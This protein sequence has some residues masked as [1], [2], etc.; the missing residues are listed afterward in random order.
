VNRSLP[1]PTFCHFRPR[2]VLAAILVTALAGCGGGGGDSTT[3]SEPPGPKAEIGT[4]PDAAAEIMEQP[5]YETSR[6]IYYVGDPES[7]DALLANRP[8]EMVLTGSTAKEFV[9]GSVYDTLGTDRRLTTP[10]YA[11]TPVSDGQVEGDLVLVASGD[12]ALGGRNAPNDKFDHTFVGDTVDH[13]YGNIAPNADRVGDPLAGLN[14]LAEQ[15]AD[16]G[17]ERVDGDVVIDT[18]LWDTFDG[19]EGPLT[20]IFVN[21]NIVDLDVTGTSE[22]EPAEVEVTPETGYFEVE[23][24][25]ETVGKDG[26][27]ELEVSESPD[28]PAVLVV[29]GKIAEGHSQLAIFSVEDAAAW[30]RALFIEALERADVEVDAPARGENDESGL[31]ASDSYPKDQELASLKSPPLSAFGSTI[32]EVSYNA[33]ANAFLCLLAVEAGSKDCNTGLE[34]MYDLAEEA[35]L[36]T[37]DLFLVDGQGADPASTTPRQMGRWLQWSMEQPWGEV[38]VEGQPI[39]GETGSLAPYGRN[40]PAAGKVAAKSGTSIDI[41]KVTA[42]MFSQVQSLSGYLTLED[43]TVLVFGLSQSGGTFPEVYEGLV[44]AGADVADVAAAFQES[45]SE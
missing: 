45:L 41:D 23:S 27:T 35:G 3:A 19:Q 33:G 11:T 6:W 30:A 8:D 37:D 29:S 10:V 16:A 9:V 40:S 22:G 36:D 24:E 1:L 12:L 34:T 43:G 26:E 28:D 7:G 31:P 2:E 32:L 5:P 39:L 25:V 17:V 38:F 4:L 42:R 20:P 14:D 44:D 18:S 21:D 13:V 15:I